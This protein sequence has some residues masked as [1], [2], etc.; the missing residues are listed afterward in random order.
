[1]AALRE[2]SGTR[3]ASGPGRKAAF[4]P[5]M[6]R[7]EPEHAVHGRHHPAPAPLPRLCWNK[8]SALSDQYG[9]VCLQCVSTPGTANLHP[10][11]VFDC[12]RAGELERAEGVW[13]RHIEALRC[14]GRRAHRRAWRRRREKRALMG[15][16]FSR[17][18]S[19]PAGA[20]ENARSTGQGLLNP[21]KVFPTLHAC[22]ELGSMHV[23][24]GAHGPSAICRGCKRDPYADK[25]ERDRRCRAP[26]PPIKARRWRSSRER[27]SAISGGR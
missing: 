16:M 7:L 1:V 15:E 2:R 3:P 9:L 20:A 8:I 19:G 18:R 27:A 12:M 22:V 23:H 24:E 25:R 17:C 5:P 4:R 11:I 14:G 6:G 26:R 13:C 21:G 10:L